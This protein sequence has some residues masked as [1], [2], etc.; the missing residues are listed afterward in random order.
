MHDR[1]G[2]FRNPDQVRLETLFSVTCPAIGGL[3]LDFL[4]LCF[5]Y[6]LDAIMDKGVA[7]K[8]RGWKDGDNQGL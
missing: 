3:L 5:D 8:S 1:F 6:A 2:P 7:K 4:I